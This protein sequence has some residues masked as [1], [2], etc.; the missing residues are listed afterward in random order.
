LIAFIL[1]QNQFNNVMIIQDNE[2]N[3]PEDPLIEDP[4]IAYRT[5]ASVMNGLIF[6]A[7]LKCSQRPPASEVTVDGLYLG[8][9]AKEGWSRM[10]LESS[11][12]RRRKVQVRMIDYGNTVD[13]VWEKGLWDLNEIS[14]DLASIPVHQSVVLPLSCLCARVISLNGIDVQSTEATVQSFA[15]RH[16]YPY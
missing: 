8:Y 14:P 5:K 9:N 4:C 6:I 15:R 10:R 11:I 13:T 7:G 16:L 12:V 3:V 1:S 2:P